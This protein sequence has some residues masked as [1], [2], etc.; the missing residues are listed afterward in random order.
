M[1]KV[2]LG[3]TALAVASFVGAQQAKAQFEV[4]V[5]GYTE[6]KFGY[7][8]T[9][10]DFAPDYDNFDLKSDSEIH[11]NAKQTLENG[12]TFA[13]H[14]ELEAETNTADQIDETYVT[15]SGS[16]GQLLLG[17]ENSAGYKMTYGAPD[18][19]FTNVNSGDQTNWLPSFGF[20]TTAAGYFRR[21]LGSTYI[22]LNGNNDAQRVTYF[23]PRWNGLQI[24]ASFTPDALQD[25]NSALPETRTFR[26][27][28]DVSA[29]Y[30]NSFDGFDIAVSGRYGVADNNAG[31]SNPDLWGAGINLGYMGFT[32][33]GSYVDANDQGANSGHAWDAGV[34]YTTG[35]W[36]ASFTYF[37]GDAEGSVGLAGDEENDSFEFAVTY[38]LGPGVTVEGSVTHVAFDDND[39]G[40]N[41]SDRATYG[42]LGVKLSF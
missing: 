11:F 2:L 22:E 28:F 25:N 19:S 15:V 37:H 29:N 14:V 13:F 33:G 17:S 27:A 16:F 7:A 34:S 23:T 3:T 8:S 39:A 26:N 10:V 18:V 21:V 1:K 40:Q 38:D 6:Q 42:I 41:F 30:V 24:G 5:G 35:P 20:G 31:G 32:I 36:G 12:L 9:S 4:S